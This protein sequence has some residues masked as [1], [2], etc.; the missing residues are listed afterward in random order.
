MKKDRQKSIAITDENWKLAKRAADR[1][2]PQT[3]RPKWINAAIQKQARE[4]GL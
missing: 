3:T 1:S 4:Q 2:V